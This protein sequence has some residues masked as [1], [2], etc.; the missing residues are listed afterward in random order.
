[1][2]VAH[3]ADADL[4]GGHNRRVASF[5]A[6]GPGGPQPIRRVGSDPRELPPR[7][8]G[9]ERGPMEGDQERD[10]TAATGAQSPRSHSPVEPGRK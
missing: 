3:G 6:S 1:M 2:R 7:R 8:R 5:C 10:R 4:P 9:P